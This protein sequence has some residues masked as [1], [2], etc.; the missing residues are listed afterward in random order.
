MR[1]AIYARVSTER[2]ER[3]QTINSQL[4]ALRAWVISNGHTPTRPM[5]SATRA[6]AAPGSTDL[7]LT[8]CVTSSATAPSSS[9]SC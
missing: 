3:Q 4:E 1:A 9:S 5:S 7:A 6:T 2:Q 8:P